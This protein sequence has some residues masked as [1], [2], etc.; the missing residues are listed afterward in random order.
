MPCMLDTSNLAVED[1]EGVYSAARACLLELEGQ[2]ATYSPVFGNEFSQTVGE[3][4]SNAERANDAASET[5][6]EIGASKGKGEAE[7]TGVGMIQLMLGGGV[8]GVRTHSRW[9]N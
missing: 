4:L 6:K 1:R 2:V 5:L 3:S 9:R 8:R 7:G